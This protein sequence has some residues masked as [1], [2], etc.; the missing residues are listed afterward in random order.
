MSANDCGTLYMGEGGRRIRVQLMRLPSLLHVAKAEAS[1]DPLRGFALMHFERESNYL[2][3]WLW[4]S[5]ASDG[6]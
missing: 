5:E 3:P 4:S 6:I 2:G 1:G